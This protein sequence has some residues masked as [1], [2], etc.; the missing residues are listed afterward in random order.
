M[1]TCNFKIAIRSGVLLI[2]AFCLSCTPSGQ[3]LLTVQILHDGVVLYEGQRG[4][5]D[6]TPVEEMWEEVSDISFVDVVGD[7]SVQNDSEEIRDISGEIVIRIWHV[8]QKLTECS[9]GKLSLHRQDAGDSWIIASP[10]AKRI[11]EAA[12]Q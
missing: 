1:N 5:P 6:Y 12:D 11:R 10:S 2:L 7:D 4:V 3:R 9:F 8:E